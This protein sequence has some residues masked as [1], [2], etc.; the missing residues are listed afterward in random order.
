MRDRVFAIDVLLL[1]HYD[2]MTI[3][4]IIHT[5]I[6]T[7]CHTQLWRGRHIYKCMDINICDGGWSEWML[8]C[9][10]MKAWDFLHMCHI[11]AHKCLILTF[12]YDN[13]K[14]IICNLERQPRSL[15]FRS[16]ACSL[17]HCLCA[18]GAVRCLNAMEQ[19]NHTKLALKQHYN[20]MSYSYTAVVHSNDPSD[21][22]KRRKFGGLIMI[23]SLEWDF[24]ESKMAISSEPTSYNITRTPSIPSKRWQTR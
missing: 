2:T 16:L 20:R 12:L 19:V 23:S 17:A 24:G 5:H 22:W 15:L 14:Y 3:L 9:D 4:Y 7:L 8:W 6:H 21:E 18:L 11:L 13:V 1:R 10:A